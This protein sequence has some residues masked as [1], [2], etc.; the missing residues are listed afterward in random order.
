[1]TGKFEIKKTA[2]GKFLFNLLA[3]NGQV[4]LTSQTY[5]AKSG[6][7]QGIASVRENAI[8]DDRF[9]RNTSSSGQPY[10]NLKAGNAQVIGRSQ[11]YS[12]ADA[13]ENGIASVKNHAPNAKIEDQAA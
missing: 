2:D 4:I 10:F 3:S 1:M 13:M 7:V 6:A 9:E 8:I 5:Q 11:M 12:S